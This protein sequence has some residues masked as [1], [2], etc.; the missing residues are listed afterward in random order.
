MA[1]NKYT[2]SSSIVK[3]II[4]GD[5]EAKKQSRTVPKVTV[6]KVT[7]TAPKKEKEENK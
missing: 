2:K 3:S 1:I 7:T 4:K 6:P 5:D